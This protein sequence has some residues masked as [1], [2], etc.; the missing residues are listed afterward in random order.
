[1][2]VRHRGIPFLSSIYRILSNILLSRSTPY[3]KE[4]VG[5]HQCG[6]Q[7]NKSTTDHIFCIPKIREKKLDYKEAVHHLFIDFR[8]AY[9]SVRRGLV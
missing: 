1:V 6:F 2:Y 5:D 8:K 9:D 3:A 7:H 4:I